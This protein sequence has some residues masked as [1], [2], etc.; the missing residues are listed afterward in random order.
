MPLVLAGYGVG[1]LVGTNAG[2]YFGGRRPLATI[3]AAAIAGTLVLLLL[4][5]SLSSSPVAAIV[6]VV[7]LDVVAM[8]VPPVATAL[9]VRFAGNAPTLAVAVPSFDT[10]IAVGSSI[11]ARA[12]DSSLG[13]TGPALVGTVE[14][15]LALLP[16]S[17]LAATRAT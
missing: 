12:L 6:L 4:Q 10:G 3:T 16:L 7:L 8:A 9:S 2:G 14:V 15:A 17:V 13:L 5:T 1:A 11:A